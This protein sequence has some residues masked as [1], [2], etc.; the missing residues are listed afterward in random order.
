MGLWVTGPEKPDNNQEAQAQLNSDCEVQGQSEANGVECGT[1]C[2]WAQQKLLAVTKSE[3][4]VLSVPVQ[5]RFFLRIR[6]GSQKPFRIALRH[7][8][9]GLAQ[10]QAESR[11]QYR[12]ADCGRR[13]NR[14][15]CKSL[16]TDKICL[17][18]LPSLDTNRCSTETDA[19][20]DFSTK[21]NI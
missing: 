13:E 11:A 15:V 6:R 9:R 12:K 18:V 5:P 10:Y 19:A 8:R 16:A 3:Q 7:E 20:S 4:T 2:R 17:E 21:T 14:F 1:G